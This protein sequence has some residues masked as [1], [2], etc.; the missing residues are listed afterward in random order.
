MMKMMIEQYMDLR[1]FSSVP[2]N[3]KHHEKGPTTILVY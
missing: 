3:I 2:A 1:A